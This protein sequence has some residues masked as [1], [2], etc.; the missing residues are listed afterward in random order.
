MFCA[1]NVC[2]TA[3]LPVV[4]FLQKVWNRLA[5]IEPKERF[6]QMSHARLVGYSMVCTLSNT[7]LFTIPCVWKTSYYGKV[8]HL[9]FCT[10]D[11]LS[12]YKVELVLEHWTFFAGW[13]SWSHRRPT[14]M[15]CTGLRFSLLLKWECVLLR[16]HHD[17]LCYM[18]LIVSDCVVIWYDELTS[19]L[20]FITIRA[21]LFHRTDCADQ[22][23]PTSLSLVC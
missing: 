1:V 10:R 9:N 4:F 14:V 7:V 11:A 18:V 15:T 3:G 8:V 12:A 2:K 20:W 23:T 21:R 6:V 16:L 17:S 13:L 22:L 5:V 19:Q